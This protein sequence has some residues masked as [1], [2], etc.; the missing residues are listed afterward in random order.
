MNNFVTFCIGHL[1]SIDSL[2]YTAI[3]NVDIFHHVISKTHTC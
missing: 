3:S 1:E 2:N